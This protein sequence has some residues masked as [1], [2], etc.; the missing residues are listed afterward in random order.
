[1]PFLAIFA[2]KQ[3]SKRKMKQRTALLLLASALMAWPWRGVAQQSHDE[4][5]GQSCTSIMVSKGAST[6]GSVI[7]SHSCDG[8]Y[9]TWLT[10]EPARDYPRDT[11][12]AIYKG[13]LKTETPYDHRNVTQAGTI[14]QVGHVYAFLNTAYPCLN[15]HQLAIGE[16]TIVGADTLVNPKAMFLVEELQRIALQ[17]CT[18]AR[19]AIKLIGQLIEQY[20]YA[21]YG[22]CLTIADK[23]EVWHLEMFGEGPDRIGGVWAAQRIPEGHVGVSA[24]ISRIGELRTDDPEHFMAS[25][26]VQDVAKRLGLWDGKQ[27][28]KFWKAF[29]DRKKPFMVREYFILNKLAPS[30]KLSMDMA[31]LPFSVKP[32]KKVSVHDVMALYR[33]T[34]EGTPYDMTQ[35]LKVEQQRTVNGKKVKEMV[36]SPTANPWLTTETRNL[37][38][39]LKPNAVT[40]QRTVAV[41]WCSYSHIIQLRSWLPDQLGGLAWF[42]FDNPGQSPRIPI[43]SGC[44]QLPPSFALC[45]QKQYR[46]ETPLWSYRRANR[47]ATVQWQSTKQGMLDEVA[48][49]E[50]MVADGTAQLERTVAQ[51]MAD[52][53]ADEATALINRYTR[54]MLHQ[55][56]ARWA[57][58]EAEY[59][60]NLWRGF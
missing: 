35:N 51:L 17:R 60:H 14:P 5:F 29:G 10:V 56:S 42:S 49:F 6:D 7:T 55:T 13:L 44:T 59:W 39:A 16:T 48:H 30:L 41:A 38:N 24:N 26:N 18:T 8:R 2:R 34:Y 22:E 53:K 20:G 45:G 58:L 28:F 37:Y 9:R 32:D 1:M 57:E 4:H 46:P 54:D 21:D 25:A 27:P 50:R 12:T 52:G 40:F 47:L 19:E 43:Y 11:V 31:E 33:E 15:E 36:K 3:I 23:N